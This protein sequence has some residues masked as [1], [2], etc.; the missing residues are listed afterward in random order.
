MKNFQMVQVKNEKYLYIP[1]FH[2]N[3]FIQKKKN[4]TWPLKGILTLFNFNV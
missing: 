2:D 3:V 1:I 4:A